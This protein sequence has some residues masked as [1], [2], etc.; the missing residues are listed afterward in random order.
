M[1]SEDDADS[2]C[3]PK[4]DFCALMEPERGKNIF[5]KVDF[6]KSNEHFPQFLSLPLNNI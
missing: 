1:S 6:L 5:F 4:L 3:F 2:S